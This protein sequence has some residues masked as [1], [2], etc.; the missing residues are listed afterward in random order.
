MK[1]LLANPALLRLEKIVARTAAIT[2]VMH[3]TKLS[4]LCPV[5]QRPSSSIHSRYQRCLADLPWEGIAVR[6]EL[7]TRKFFCRYDNCVRQ[8]FCERLPEVVAPYARQT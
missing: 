6:V 4:A 8:V 3:T 1:T 2:L 7:Y 5:C